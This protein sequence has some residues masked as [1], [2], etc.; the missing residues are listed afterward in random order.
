[1]EETT[2]MCSMCRKVKPISEFRLM[3]QTKKR[4]AYCRECEKIYQRE[5]KKQ[6]REMN[7]DMIVRLKCAIVDS[8]LNNSEIARRVGVSRTMIQSYWS[9]QG[10]PN[11]HTFRNLCKVLNVNADWL[12]FGRGQKNANS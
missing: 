12:L 10:I 5:Y 9:N 2:K 3:N 11:L 1:M 6:Q 7:K 8:G 4:N